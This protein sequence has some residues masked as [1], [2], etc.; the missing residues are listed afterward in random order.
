M[1]P[2]VT[3]VEFGDGVVRVEV[4]GLWVAV[5]HSRP[6]GQPFDTFVRR[7]VEKTYSFAKSFGGA[8]PDV[9]ICDVT[10]AVVEAVTSHPEFPA[11]D[12]H[13]A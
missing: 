10:D 7:A 6:D 2:E 5:A 1:V 13:S 12:V 11:W 9:A 4:V 3:S 8:V